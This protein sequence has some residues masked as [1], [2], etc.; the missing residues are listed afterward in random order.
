MNCIWGVAF[1]VLLVNLP[2]GFWRAGTA[3]FSLPWILAV[4]LPV[5]MVAGFR[6][7]S[8]LGWQPATFPFLVGA[9]FTGQFL[10]GRIRRLRDE[11]R[12][13]ESRAKE[14]ASMAAG[15][16]AADQG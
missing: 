15:S 6:I 10:G 16:P 3:R 5:P 8:G 9:Y 4:H 13:R 7:I 1:A 2:F 14:P 11:T 12:A